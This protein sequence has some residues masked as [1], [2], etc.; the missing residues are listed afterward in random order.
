MSSPKKVGSK[1]FKSEKIWAQKNLIKK[2][3]SKKFLGLNKILGLKEFEIRIKLGSGNIFG[4]QNCVFLK[5]FWVLKN[6][7]YEK[8]VDP[9]QFQVKK[10]VGF[11]NILDLK[12]FWIRKILG[13][14]LTQDLTKLSTFGLSLVGSLNKDR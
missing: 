9:K 7:E 13:L 6:C 8:I 5:K 14:T 3:G 10:Y 1:N 11:K 12:I 4:P 2:I